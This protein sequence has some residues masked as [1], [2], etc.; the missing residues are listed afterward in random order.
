MNLVNLVLHPL[1]LTVFLPLVGVL[2]ILFMKPEWKNAIRWIALASLYRY[3]CHLGG[4]ADL[5]PGR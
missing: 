3:L 5:F 2:V 1:T 4:D